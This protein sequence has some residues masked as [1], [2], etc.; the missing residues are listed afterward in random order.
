MLNVNETI[1]GLPNL[2]DDE[3]ELLEISI[4]S[5]VLDED[6]K[7]ALLEAIDD[8]WEERDEDSDE[9]EDDVFADEIDADLVDED[10]DELE[11]E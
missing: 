8:E 7:D 11:F 2:S 9:G 5:E 6:E 10:E 4:E 1:E 3:L